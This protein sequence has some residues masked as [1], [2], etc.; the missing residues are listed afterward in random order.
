MAT[1]I[2]IWTITGMTTTQAQQQQVAVA[3]RSQEEFSSEATC[4][5]ARAQILGPSMEHVGNL[6][7][8]TVRA[9]CTKK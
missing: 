5:A 2:L 7:T 3:T 1:W 6:Y 4:N 9:M 8:V